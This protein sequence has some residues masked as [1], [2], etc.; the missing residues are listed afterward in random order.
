MLPL[1][2]FFRQYPFLL[3]LAVLLLCDLLKGLDRLI[4]KP[5]D[6]RNGG[7]VKVCFGVGGIP[8]SH[9]AFV[10]SLLTL[11]GMREGI[12]STLFAVAFVFAGVVWHDAIYVRKQHTFIEVV[13]GI[14]FGAFLTLLFY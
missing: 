14:V 7:W 13:I 9:S 5:A 12:A 2:E 10:A 1:Q 11:V 3:P 8:S 6:L 4:R